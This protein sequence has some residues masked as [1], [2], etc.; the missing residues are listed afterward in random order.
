MEM[1]ENMKKIRNT[2]KAVGFCLLGVVVASCA[3]MLESESTRQDFDPGM[4]GKT[5]SLFYTFGIFAAMQELADQYVLQGEMRG[6]LLETTAYTDNNLRRLADFSATT[7][8]KYDS[9]Y[10]YYKVINN[11]NYYIAHR[12]TALSTNSRNV[13]IHEYAAVMAIRAWA[14]LQLGRNYQK[15]P[16]FTRPLTQISDINDNDFPELTLE[17]IVAQLAPDLEKF[18]KYD[19]PNAGYSYSGSTMPA[20]GAPNWTN[21]SKGFM[22]GLCYIPVDVILGDLYLEAGDYSNAARHFITY[23]NEVSPIVPSN[24]TATMRNKSMETEG[25]VVTEQLPDSKLVTSLSSWSQIFN[26]NSTTDI[27]T[28]IPMPATK[29]WGHTTQLPL[30]FGADFYATPD[31][32]S[33]IKR[34]SGLPLVTEI[35]VKPSTVLN[36]LSDS[37]EFYHYTWAD[38]TN[39]DY[40]KVTYS[41]V[42]DMR[43]RNVIDQQT[44]NSENLQWITKYDNANIILYRMSTILLRLAEALNRLE[45]PDAAFGILK[46]GI[47]YAMLAPGNTYMTAESQ[48]KLKSEYPLLDLAVIA[49]KYLTVEG[50]ITTYSGIH[51]HGAGQA[52]SDFKYETKKISGENVTTISYIPKPTSPYTFD[53]IVGLKLKE[54]QETF[55]ASV[56]ATKRDTI[57]AVEDLI[58]DELALE[59]AFEGNRY[60]D[61]MRLARHKNSAGLYGADFGSKWFAAKLAFKN[62]VV[63]LK[64]PENWYLPFK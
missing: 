50:V 55:G 48:A 28:Y 10:V 27:I 40:T 12:D 36:T 51:G 2:I 46:D 60:F 21:S 23:L 14:Y 32:A 25:E 9:A 61:L 33:G 11:C 37:T 15:V 59:L 64:D 42:G 41:K 17:E 38:A 4:D 7:A 54:I 6:D 53:R 44:V 58:C 20:E 39:V 63:D 22:P 47:G 16:F 24:M 62:P 49:R 56:G 34:S 30:I 1:K 26:W 13:V 8:N 3:D 29:Q 35:Q 19:V 45:M 52:T 18:T 31:E 57:N 43:L 5:D